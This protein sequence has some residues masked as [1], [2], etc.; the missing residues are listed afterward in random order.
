MI[1]HDQNGFLIHYSM[2][3]NFKI[4]LELL[5]EQPDIKEK[6]GRNGKEYIA[7]FNIQSIGE[8]FYQFITSST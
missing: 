8:K 3:M 2:M 7:K 5:M 4:K 6:F 1:I